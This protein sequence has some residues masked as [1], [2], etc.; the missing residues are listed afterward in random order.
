[1]KVTTKTRTN[2]GPIGRIF[3]SIIMVIIGIVLGM[4]SSYM[5]KQGA[6]LKERCTYAV[7]ATVISFERSDNSDS[8]SAVTPV[9]EYEYK[10][11]TYT[12][13]SGTY[14]SSFK[15]KFKTGQVYPILIAPDDPL[16]I[17]SK[18]IAA[19]DSTMFNILRW[20]GVA[21]VA[22]GI[23][24]FVFS[25]VLL[26]AIGGAIGLTIREIANRKKISQ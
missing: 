9:F 24:S 17:Y 18:D 10:G 4:V 16:E 19:S 15:D 26:V 25:I 23:I 5:I 7:D 13:K 1:M 11:E 6:A 21:L 3:G 8:S 12:S 2:Q 20:V 22:I 14:S